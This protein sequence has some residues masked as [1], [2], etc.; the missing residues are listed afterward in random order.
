[1]ELPV[2]IHSLLKKAA[3]EAGDQTLWN[4][5]E[6]K[7]SMS[8]KD[9]LLNVDRLA[10]GFQQLGIVKGTHVAVML[11]NRPSMPLSWFALGTLG[12]VMVPVNTSY[13]NRELTFVL[14]NSDAQF[15][16]THDSLLG[17]VREVLA[18]GA[19]KLNS[20]QVI[21]EGANQEFSS[22]N[23]ALA[24]EPRAAVPADVGRH[25][26]LNIQYT[27]GTTGFPKGCMLTQE[28]WLTSGI[29]N[30]FRDG[31]VYKNILA[32]TPFYYMD[33]QWLLLMA[34]Y[35]RGTLFVA[36]RQ[37]A[38]RFMDWVRDYKINFCLFPYLVFKQPPTPSDGNNEVVRANVYGVP[39]DIH[40]SIEQRFD[41]VAREAFGMTEV[42]PAMSMPIEATDMV[43]SGSCGV[44][45][46][47]RE[48][49][50][51]DEE[52]ND[53]AQGQ[54]GELLIRGQG[55]ML[56]Y[57]KNDEAT[58]NAF[59][60]GWFRSGDMFRQDE[61][62]YFYIEGRYKDMIRRSAENIAAREIEAVMNGI[63]EVRES[64][65]VGVTDPTRGEEV[66][67]Y[68]VVKPGVTKDIET[69]KLIIAG[70]QKN[71]A[72]FKVPRY[73]TFIDDLPKTASLK[74]AKATLR[75]KKSTD[76]QIYDRVA[77][78]WIGASVERS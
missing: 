16:V 7:E 50:I 48:C 28:Y 31:R 49:R 62:G 11:P 10:A 74:V 39:R 25:D 69:L 19:V 45:S 1:M 18:G 73:Y 78:A 34:I 12:A 52:G 65:A 2:N 56:G 70:C 22:W 46:P 35:Q 40:R 32:P 15:L 68:V 61:R 36:N 9:V 17:L 4:F 43:G 24:T 30:A 3:E 33:P 67:A 63:S 55:I 41:L 59:L 37:S 26:L 76:E 6:L 47:Y 77:D 66:K 21:V 20:A 72:K 44:P 57:Y 58:K 8:Y 60:A 71:L 14:N 51:V 42:G 64:A 38:T 23:S 29:V 53:V 27:S 54:L 13:M 75:E 5:F